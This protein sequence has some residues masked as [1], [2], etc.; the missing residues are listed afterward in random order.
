MQIDLERALGAASQRGSVGERE[1]V[2]HEALHRL[3]LARRQARERVSDSTR[4]LS[5]SEPSRWIGRFID[6]AFEREWCVHLAHIL[7]ANTA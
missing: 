3:A 5:L 6:M 2:Q 1:F 4:G 7:P